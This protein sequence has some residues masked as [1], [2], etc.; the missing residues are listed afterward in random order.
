MRVRYLA[1]VKEYMIESQDRRY[2]IERC[3]H[4]CILEEIEW[5]CNDLSY[6]GEFNT[7]GGALEAVM[8]NEMEEG[9]TL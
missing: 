5:P 3:N 6:I 4:K 7:L 8:R 2:V 1:D 9:E